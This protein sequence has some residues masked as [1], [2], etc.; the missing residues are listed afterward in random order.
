MRATPRSTASIWE[1][2][3]NSNA[4]TRVAAVL[5]MI[6]LLAAPSHAVAGTA[7]TS[8]PFARVYL[9]LRGCTS[10]SHCRTS[11]R[12]MV[13]PNAKGAETTFGEDR[14]EVRYTKPGPVPLRDVIRSLAQSRLH[15]LSLVDV[16]FEATG[17]VAVGEDGT[18]RFVLAKTGQTF[19][20]AAATGLRLP[21][22]GSSVRVVALVEGWRS[23]GALSLLAREVRSGA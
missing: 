15:D 5:G 11:I 18:R 8:A 12:Q 6:C 20:I 4:L 16:L 1:S 23:K 22:P 19:P 7:A 3:L 14:V 13:R 17:T 9:A 10:C 2:P 21:T